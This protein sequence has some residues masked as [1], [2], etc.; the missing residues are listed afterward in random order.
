MF[1][2]LL[3][4][5]LLAPPP[6]RPELQRPNP[7]H[8]QPVDWSTLDRSVLDHSHYLTAP[9]GKRGRLRAEGGRIVDG[10]GNRVRFWGINVTGATCTPSH[11][12]A[13]RLA[14]IFARLGFNRVRFHHLDAGWGRIL[15]EGDTTR[16]LDPDALD[17]LGYFVAALKAKGIYSNLN[18]NVG[19]EYRSGDGVKDFGT[20]G[21]GKGP[22]YFDPQLI[23]LQKEYARQLLT[24]ENPHTGLTFAEDPAV[25]TVEVMNENSLLEAWGNG[26]FAA[27]PRWGEPYYGGTWG[28]VPDSYVTDLHRLY[29]EWA[30]ATLTPIE[31]RALR[32]SAGAAA[33]PIPLTTVEEQA[34]G[35]PARVASDARFLEQLETRFLT[36]MR[37]FL[38]EDLLEGQ[39]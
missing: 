26:R 38:R 9:A 18:L 24:F 37:R 14:A 7:T 10:E 33:G 11:E 13:D 23:A 27:R 21:Y 6:A 29:G 15:A 16:R 12:D 8:P 28:Q 30:D 36:E 25:C 35:D 20:L 39:R 2:L 5:L 4:A 22:T 17:R 19:R 31:L 1:A 34:T 3:P 32:T